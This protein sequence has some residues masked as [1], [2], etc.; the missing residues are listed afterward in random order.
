[1]LRA[2]NII[3]QQLEQQIEVWE[4]LIHKDSRNRVIRLV[5]AALNPTADF[6]PVYRCY[7]FGTDWC[8]ILIGTRL[9]APISESARQLV[10]RV[11]FMSAIFRGGQNSPITTRNHL[12]AGS[13]KLL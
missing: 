1:M 6:I 2:Y 9:F 12:N 11:G 8:T 3:S 5:I 4:W 7:A 10:Q 13:A